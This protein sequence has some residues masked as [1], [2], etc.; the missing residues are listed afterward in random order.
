V[1]ER[2]WTIPADKGARTSVKLQLRI[3]NQTD[4]PLRFSRFD[5][6]FPRMNGP[7]EKPLHPDGGRRETL[8][9]HE[10]DFPLVRPGKSTTFSI[11]A[12]LFRQ[13]GKLRFGGSDGFGGVWGFSEGFTT[14]RYQVSVHYENHQDKA[15][16]SE[17]IA[18]GDRVRTGFWTG[19]VDTP[20]INVSIV[21][22]GTKTVVKR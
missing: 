11:D 8:P 15:E 6:I 22:P 3:T 12:E 18:Q 13:N 1:P 20:F 7:D 14:G 19:A 4:R 17:K 2:A 10:S 5:T 21:E 16:V 9:A